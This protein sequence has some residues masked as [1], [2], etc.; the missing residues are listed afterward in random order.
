[1]TRYL[2]TAKC[3]CGN[4]LKATHDSWREYDY[5]CSECGKKFTEKDFV[6]TESEDVA[7]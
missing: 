1:M 7:G 2:L 3:G 6:K 5:I 4:K